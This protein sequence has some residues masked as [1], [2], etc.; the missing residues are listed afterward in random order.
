MSSTTI[1][2]RNCWTNEDLCCEY[3]W[4]CSQFNSLCAQTAALRAVGNIVTGTDEQT[5]VVLNCDALSHF[6]ALLT[7]PK[8][9]INK[10]KKKKKLCSLTLLYMNTPPYCKS[11]VFSGGDEIRDL[12]LVWMRMTGVD[13]RSSRHLEQFTTRRTKKIQRIPVG[14]GGRRKKDKFE[15]GEK[16]CVCAC[17]W[18]CE[19]MG[20]WLKG[21]EDLESLLIKECIWDLSLKTRPPLVVTWL[22]IRASKPPSPHPQHPVSTRGSPYRWIFG[23]WSS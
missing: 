9:K 11:Q 3:P 5:Q 18:M 23:F 17:G 19:T 8:E 7:H 15:G 22:M 1:K 4:K 13:S 21:A 20:W 14:G 16:G 2:N 10:V 6:P 12:V